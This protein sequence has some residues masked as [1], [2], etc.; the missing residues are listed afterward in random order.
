LRNEGRPH[1]NV[2]RSRLQ[3]TALSIIS[4]ALAQRPKPQLVNVHNFIRADTDVY[5]GKA[6]IGDGALGKLSV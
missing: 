2:A 6:A 1:E 5:F 4:P 3:F